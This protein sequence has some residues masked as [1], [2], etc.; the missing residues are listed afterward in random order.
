MSK[1]KKSDSTP[2][3]PGKK[4]EAK[5]DE[6]KNVAYMSGRFLLATPAMGDPRFKNT[7]IYVCSHDA[8]GAMG[9]IVNKSKGGLL[10]SDLLEQIGVEGDV[11]VADTPVLN[12]GPVDIDRGF[13]LHSSD[14]HKDETSLK[15][16]DTLTLTSTKDVLE[17]LVSDEAPEKAMLAIGY[18]GWGEGQL[19]SEIMQNGWLVVDADETMIFGEDLDTKRK[20][21]FDA[22]GVSPE[23]LSF[24][25]GTA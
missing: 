11:R 2:L 19:E 18:C 14:Y 10:I 3:N 9:I 12:G 1:S 13:V 21:A 24:L 22:L 8:H 4:S 5:T 17:A 6:K 15:L 23:T 16:S 25:G 20:K 7:L